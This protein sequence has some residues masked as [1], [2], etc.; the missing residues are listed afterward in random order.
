MCPIV[1]ICLKE[2]GESVRSMLAA[3]DFAKC[4]FEYD[5][6]A[7]QKLDEL[8]Q[9]LKELEASRQSLALEAVGERQHV[10]K[11]KILYD[12]YLLEMKKVEV[13]ESC[14]SSRKTFVIEGWVPKHKEEYVKELHRQKLQIRF[15]GVQGRLQ[16]RNAAHP[17][18]KQ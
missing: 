17:H 9:E 16:G 5:M 1:A 18:Q 8:E 4:P 13:I 15:G 6:T 11:L 7:R 3:N 10:T 2:D 14:S 12:F